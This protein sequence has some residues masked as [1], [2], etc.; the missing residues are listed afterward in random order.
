MFY[1]CV[2]LMAFLV[3]FIIGSFVASLTIK[4]STCFFNTTIF[5]LQHPNDSVTLKNDFSTLKIS[6]LLR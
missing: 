4:L 1:S 3:A 5:E 2:Y 6:F